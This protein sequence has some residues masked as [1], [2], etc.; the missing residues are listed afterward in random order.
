MQSHKERQNRSVNLARR[1]RI[2]NE[3][4]RRLLGTWREAP[5]SDPPSRA[6]VALRLLQSLRNATS[7]AHSN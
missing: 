2:L 7:V 5:S 6:K 3:A 4:A 1:A